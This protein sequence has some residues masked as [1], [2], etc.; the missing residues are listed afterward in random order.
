LH[1]KM[2]MVLLL[3][4]WGD[5]VIRNRRFARH[6]PGVSELLAG[7]RTLAVILGGAVDLVFK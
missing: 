2:I 7:D 4:S 1:L 3:W 6:P 5:G